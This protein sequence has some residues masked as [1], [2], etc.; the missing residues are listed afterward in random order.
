MSERSDSAWE[1]YHV[2][3]RELDAVFLMLAAIHELIE[4]RLTQ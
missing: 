3:D 4:Q 2:P 1:A